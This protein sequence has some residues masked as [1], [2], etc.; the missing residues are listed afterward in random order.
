[1]KA[2]TQIILEWISQ[3]T[4]L[5][6]NL[7]RLKIEEEEKRSNIYGQLNLVYDNLDFAQNLLN[8]VIEKLEKKPKLKKRRMGQRVKVVRKVKK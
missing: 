4:T 1:M 7:L 5:K 2:D 8:K 6:T 3:L